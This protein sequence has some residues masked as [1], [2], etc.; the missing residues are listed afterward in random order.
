MKCCLFFFISPTLDIE[1]INSKCAILFVFALGVERD[2]VM[3]E[4]RLVNSISAMT[5]I[6][7]GNYAVTW[8]VLLRMTLRKQCA[9]KHVVCSYTFN[10]FNKASRLRYIQM[11]YDVILGVLTDH[12]RNPA[13][14]RKFQEEQEVTVKPI[15]YF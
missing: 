8:T 9:G 1:R 13:K 5:K 15:F 12:W 14:N 3:L 6:E 11:C 4:I 10:I 7:T 2:T